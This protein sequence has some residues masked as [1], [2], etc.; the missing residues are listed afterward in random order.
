MGS[1]ELYPYLFD[2]KF[3]RDERGYLFKPFPVGSLSENEKLIFL[4]IYIAS[5][6]RNVFRGLHYQLHPH[7]QRKI[8]LVIDGEVDFYCVEVGNESNIVSHTLSKGSSQCLY[9]PRG[10]ASGYRT[11][12][13]ENLVLCASLD[14]YAP[15]F[16]RTIHY[17]SIPMLRGVKLLHSQKDSKA[18]SAGS[19]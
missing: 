3:F 11:Q 18:N 12:A 13:D 9:V 17:A 10:W 5:S 8:F 14:E 16:E 7:A 15:D 4:D 19:P 6:S 2:A 1:S